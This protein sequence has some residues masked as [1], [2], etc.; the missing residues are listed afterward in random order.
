M[1]ILIV[2]VV[3]IFC[4]SFT[5]TDVRLR[6]DT[7]TDHSTYIRFFSWQI[8]YWD[9]DRIIV[10]LYNT[11]KI[12]RNILLSDYCIYNYNLW[13]HLKN[14]VSILRTNLLWCKCDSVELG[15]RAFVLWYLYVDAESQKNKIM[16]Y[17][18]RRSLRW[19]ISYIYGH[20]IFF[21][22]FTII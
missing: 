18:T 3:Y 19:I 8:S 6:L 11:N 2:F 9:T 12:T 21:I 16:S 1:F 14:V 13:I 5:R 15:R 10:I 4:N 22:Y 7:V 20:Q 17:P